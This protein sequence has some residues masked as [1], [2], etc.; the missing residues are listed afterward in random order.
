[1][2]FELIDSGITV[3]WLKKIHENLSEKDKAIIEEILRVTN[4]WR[5]KVDQLLN[6][7][8]DVEVSTE[9]NDINWE[10]LSEVLNLSIKLSWANEDNWEKNPVHDIIA[11]LEEHW[12]FN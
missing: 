5:L 7:S 10:V 4:D 3:S 2:T 1:M 11:Y 6:D 12:S 9:E 8:S